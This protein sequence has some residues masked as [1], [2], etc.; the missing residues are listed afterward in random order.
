MIVRRCLTCLRPLPSLRNRQYHRQCRPSKQDISPAEI[1]RRQ[2]AAY[3]E[4]RARRRR[5]AA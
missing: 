5:Q 2:A 1:E 3:A 4:I